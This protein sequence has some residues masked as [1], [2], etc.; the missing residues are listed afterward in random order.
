MTNTISWPEVIWTLAAG[1]GLVFN[2]ITFFRSLVDLLTLKI[3]KINSIREYSALT[4]LMAY[5]TWAFVQFIFVLIGVD[6]MTREPRPGGVKRQ[7]FSLVC[8]LTVSV[9][10]SC[11][12]FII[13]R[14]RQALISKIKE[15]EEEVI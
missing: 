14:R 8:F 2:M 4:T 10:L 3:R 5:G 7:I 9:L 11:T 1:V 12:A 13:E 6:A 15:L